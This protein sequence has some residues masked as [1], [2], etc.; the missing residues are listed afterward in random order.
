MKE[1]NSYNLLVFCGSKPGNNK[2]YTAACDELAKHMKTYDFGLVYGGGKVGI[3]GAI[4][5]ACMKEE[6][7]VCGVIPTF[8]KEKELAH[9]GIDECIEVES[10]HARKQL[11][12]EQADAIVALPGGIGTLEEWIEMMT[13]KQ[14]NIHNKPLAFLNTDGYYNNF[15]SFLKQMC[16][17]GFLDQESVDQII[18]EEDP[19]SLMEQIKK[20][21]IVI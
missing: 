6:L 11:M 19:K 10:M 14:L 9:L 21:M 15:M 17:T 12:F 5:D 13:W 8:L 18:C 3:M 2:A 7:Y 20:D 4:A 1:K 16:E